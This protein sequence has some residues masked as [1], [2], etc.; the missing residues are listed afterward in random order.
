M[1]A[2]PPI[3]IK[4]LPFQN[5]KYWR[6]TMPLSKAVLQQ[7]RKENMLSINEKKESTVHASCSSNQGMYLLKYSQVFLYNSIL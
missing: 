4:F 3:S 1:G 5:F 2:F 7:E 6:E